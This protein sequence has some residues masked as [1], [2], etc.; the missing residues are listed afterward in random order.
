MAVRIRTVYVSATLAMLFLPNFHTIEKN[1]N[2]MYAIFLNGVEVG[3]VESEDVAGE[4]LK[5]ARM[6]LALE[7][8]KLVFVNASLETQGQELLIGKVDSEA[9]VTA[10]MLSVLKGNEITDR[11]LAYMVKINELTLNIANAEG[12]VSALQAAIDKYDTNGEFKVELVLDPDREINVLTT[13]ITDSLEREQEATA[14]PNAGIEK[15]FREIDQ[16]S[17]ESVKLSFDDYDYGITDLSFEDKI[18]VIETYLPMTSLTDV[19]AATELLTQD[20]AKNTIYEVKDGDTLSQIAENVNI[21]LDQIIAMNETLES[22]NSTIRSGDE[23]IITIPEPPLSVSRK[24]TVRGNQDYDLPVEYIDNPDWYVNEKVTRTQPSAGHRE[25]AANVTYHNAEAVETDILKEVVTISPI[26]KVVER[27]TKALPTFIKPISGGR[28]TSNFGKRK[29]PKKGASTY[30]KGIDWATP[31]GT[32]VMATS[33]GVVTR[34]G[35]GRGYGYVVYIDHGNGRQ[36]R[37]GHLSKVL[38]KEGQKVSQGQKIALSGN[39]GVSTG[40]HIHFEILQN[41]TAVNPYSLMN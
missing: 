18:E 4:C 20:Q 30:H 10:N 16:N 32:A 21:P 9:D 22:E 26:A 36:S 35:W 31:V 12:V 13:K 14:L 40:P 5:N 24:E 23:L 2:N 6:Q 38:V 7:S 1:G 27:G 3:I 19:T 39:T 11:S 33:D 37:Y 8:E 41:G 17:E 25:Y 15:E 34:A 29:A 28:L